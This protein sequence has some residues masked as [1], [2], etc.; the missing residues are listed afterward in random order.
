VNH[1]LS[2]HRIRGT[3]RELLGRDGAG[4]ISG[5]GL[6]K[7]L[8]NRFGAAGNTERVFRIWR[9][10][11]EA[12]AARSRE[13]GRASA[14]APGPADPREVLELKQRLLLAESAA[15]ENLARAERAEYRE[16]AHQD[17]WAGEIDRLRQAARSQP[18]SALMIRNLQE[19]VFKLSRELAVAR[20]A[21]GI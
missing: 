3:C 7:E 10:E 9:E 8:R 2:E 11:T 6:R 13:A 19:Q 12:S 16:Q 17:T 18:D 20:G 15:A 14:P 1:K 4:A 21:S 5:R